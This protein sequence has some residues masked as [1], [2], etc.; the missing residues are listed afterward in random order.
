MS[1]AAVRVQRRYDYVHQDVDRWGN[2][3]VYFRRRVGDRKIRMLEKIGSAEF[4]RR[5][6][7]LLKQSESGAFKPEPSTTPT[8]HTLRWLGVRWISSAQFKSRDP[9]TQHVTR[10]ILEAMYVEP[11]APKSTEL[12]ADWPLAHFGTKAVRILRDRKADFPEGANNRVRRLR[13]MFKWAMKPENEEL[14]VSSN[15]ALA[16]EFLMPKRA[17]GFP[18]WASTDIDKFEAHHPI[19]TRA[20]LALALLCFTGARRSDVVQLGRQHV[21]E[22]RDGP[23]LV[24]RQHKGRNKSPVT[25]DVPILPVL[26]AIIV[27]TPTTGALTFLQTSQGRPFTANGFGAWFRDRCD[28]AGVHGLSAHGLRKAAAARSAQNGAS[29]HTLMAIFGWL[30]IQQAERYTRTAERRHLATAGMHTLG[31][32][33][34]QNIPTLDLQTPQVGKFVAK[35]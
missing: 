33:G 11:I 24:W 26:Q 13:A 32:S 23:R 34:D 30:T 17:G 18:A 27:A 9:R 8:P 25:C 15:P 16:V 5:H 28:E 19:G 1:E 10:Q 29:T 6:K 35:K 7:E 4:D 31:T 21:R 2:V 22:T 3:R 12:F 20:R 14:G